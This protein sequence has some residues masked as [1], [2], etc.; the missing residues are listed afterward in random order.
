MSKS[1]TPKQREAAAKQAWLDFIAKHGLPPDIPP[2]PDEVYKDKWK[3]WCEWL[4]WNETD[5]K[6]T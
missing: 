4:G 5:P 2:N 3:G 1:L 6:L